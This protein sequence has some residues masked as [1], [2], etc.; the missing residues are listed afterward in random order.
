MPTREV[1]CQ[2]KRHEHGALAALMC[3][4][5]KPSRLASAHGDAP[6]IGPLEQRDKVLA[7]D[8]QAL[9]DRG[10]LDLARAPDFPHGFGKPV[11][12]FDSVISIALDRFDQPTTSRQSQG[13]GDVA[14]P[15]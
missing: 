8:T 9:A 13:R 11:E 1:P 10:R 15:R 7:A 14:A 3:G 4:A 6:S 12:R 5:T 2:G